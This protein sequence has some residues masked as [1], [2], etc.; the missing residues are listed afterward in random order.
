MTTER[1]S[2]ITI[3]ENKK[4]SKDLTRSELN[5]ERNSIFTVSTYKGNSREVSI[6]EKGP[7]GEIRERKAII[8]RTVQG[9]ETGVLTT[10]HFKV[11]L[12]LTKIWE[13]AGRPVNEPVRFTILKIIELLGIVDAGPNY[14][15]IKQQLMTLRQIPLTFIDSFFVPGEGS[16]KSLRPFTILNHLEIH[17]RGN[18]TE[19]RSYGEF[20]F[21]RYIL[22]S[23][24]NNHVHPLRL[25]I[26]TGFRKHRDLAILLYTYI[27]RNLA[28]RSNYEVGLQKLF[29]H[30]DLSQ[31]YIK[32]ASQ[33]KQKIQ[34]VCD[35]LEG[36]PLSTGTL[37]YCRILKVKEKNDYKLV[38]RKKP[39]S[40]EGRKNGGAMGYLPQLIKPELGSGSELVSLLVQRGLTEKQ[41]EG[42]ASAQTAEIINAQLIYLPFRLREYESQGNKVNEAAILHD[43]IRDNWSTPGGYLDAEKEKEREAERLEQER[44]A[45]LEQEE[46][47]RAEQERIGM[48]SYKEALD[49]EARTKLRD[50]AL[51]ELRSTEG[52]KEQFISEP[53]ITGKENEILRSTMGEY[54][55]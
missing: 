4:E 46:R 11:Y 3:L 6:I 41:A 14:E 32:Y 43:S 36:K 53:L 2:I 27:D 39:F 9:I 30:L 29:S 40:K 38:C 26:I 33:R 31:G 18:G 42:L 20:Q 21:D 34:P 12:T 8:G 5:L 37:S 52:V 22:E 50:R 45:H 54:E 55:G 13:E 15:M 1:E 19:Q 35:L 48:E 24:V 47:D 49:P 16:Y 44:I 25:D 51:A 17:E 28:L 7:N 23:L 10:Q